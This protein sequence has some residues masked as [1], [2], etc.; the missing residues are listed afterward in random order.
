MRF[1]TCADN[2]YEGSHRIDSPKVQQGNTTAEA[3]V[4]QYMFKDSCKARVTVLSRE[5]QL[6]H[7]L[8]SIRCYS[9][10]AHETYGPLLVAR[11][12]SLKFSEWLMVMLHANIL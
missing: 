6:G 7:C 8:P 2:D 4:V 12:L 1:A 9:L 5:E 3:K 10:N 11:R